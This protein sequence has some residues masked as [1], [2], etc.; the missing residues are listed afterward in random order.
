MSRPL[1]NDLVQEGAR[2][3][4]VE[5]LGA[6]DPVDIVSYAGKSGL[7]LE[8]TDSRDRGRIIDAIN[9]MQAGGGTN[10]SGG[11][12]LAYEV[13]RSQYRGEASMAMVEDLAEAGMREDSAKEREGFLELVRATRRL[14]RR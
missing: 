13:A 14:A 11:I 3:M 9:S 8:S 6:G 5:E 7:T 1:L 12:Q 4:L 10:G 2:R